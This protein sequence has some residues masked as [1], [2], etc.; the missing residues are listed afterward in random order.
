MEYKFFN[1]V[2]IK[3]LILKL[4]YYGISKI[5][6]KIFHSGKEKIRGY[7]GN[8]NERQINMVD[9]ICRTNTL[10]I[11]LFHEYENEVRMS[12]EAIQI[13]K[14]QITKNIILINDSQF[15]EWFNGQDLILSD[16]EIKNLADE[17]NGFKVIAYKNELIGMG[18]FVGDRI[19]NYIPKER[20]RKIQK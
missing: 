16:N 3:K 15:Q 2:E 6:I 17:K 12:I 4:E 19:V 1:D 7:S 14:N 10:G 8:L 5:P 11:Y 18:K 9:K 20:R 13:F